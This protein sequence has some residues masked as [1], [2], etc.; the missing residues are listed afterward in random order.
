MRDM[1]VKDEYSFDVLLLVLTMCVYQGACGQYGGKP[2]PQG[3]GGQL[4]GAERQGTAQ[5]GNI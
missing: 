4:R 5:N 2:I 3:T 1:Q